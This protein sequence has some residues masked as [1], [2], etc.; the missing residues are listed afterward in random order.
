MPR[1]AKIFWKFGDTLRALYFEDPGPRFK[2][3][4]RETHAP[5]PIANQIQI[6]VEAAALNHAEQLFLSG[7]Y[8]MPQNSEAIL[9]IEVSGTVSKLGPTATKWKVGDIVSA[10]LPRTGGFAEYAVT[11]ESLAFQLPQHFSF[12][13]MAAVPEVFLTAYQLLQWVAKIHKGQNI[14]IHAGASGVGTAAIQLVKSFGGH[15]LITTRSH[16]KADFCKTLGSSAEIVVHK[17]S[18][19]KEVM[20][21]T[22]GKGVDVILDCV[23]FPYF[24]ENLKS[25]ARNGTLV[26]YGTLGGEVGTLDLGNILDRWIQ[27]KGSTLQARPLSYKEKLLE[28]MLVDCAPLFASGG[29]KPVVHSTFP[30]EQASQAYAVLSQQLNMGKIVLKYH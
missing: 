3:V 5:E 9:G 18:F 2:F 6:K 4:M 17:N 11:Y 24:D 10:L 22:D 25:T 19:Y 26:M 21:L 16:H 8:P 27:I 29:L 13:E 12:V 30:L 14:L 28:A 23:G 15:P 20:D 7:I 1:H